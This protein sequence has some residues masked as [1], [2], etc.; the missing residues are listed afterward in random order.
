MTIMPDAEDPLARIAAAN[1]RIA[2]ALE[3]LVRATTDAGPKPRLKIARSPTDKSSLAAVNITQDGTLFAS[4]QNTGDAETTLV[5][6]TVH[7]G[8]LPIV[9]GI[10]ER[11]GLPQRSA[12]VLASETGPGVIL[13][14]ELDR[15]QVQGLAN[16]PLVVLLP[17]SP[18]C[19]PGMT[20]LEVEMEPAGRSDGRPGWHC[21]SSRE[22]PQRHASA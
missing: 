17:H 5:E 4:V 15:S 9:G 12:T 7:I 8:G 19:F 6:P 21:T 1:E 22:F 11:N 20:V 14:F 16:M 3:Y 13:Q 2:Q 18:G 10:I